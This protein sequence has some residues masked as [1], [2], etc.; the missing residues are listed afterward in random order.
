MR[1]WTLI[2]ESWIKPA[3]TTSPQRIRSRQT[4]LARWPAARVLRAASPNEFG[5][6]TPGAFVRIPVEGILGVAVLL[7]LPAKARPAVATLPGLALGLL[8]IMKFLDMGFFASLARPFDPVIDWILFE[9]AEVP[10]RRHRPGRRDRCLAGA[11]LAR[12]ALHDSPGC[13][14]LEPPLGP[15]QRRRQSCSPCARR[16]LARLRHLGTQV[17]RACP[18]LP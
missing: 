6:L 12:L 9:D 15:A 8:A 1:R 7:V 14:T 10:G 3:T 13:S 11:V 4:W 17:V 5:R 2:A 16:S 18:S